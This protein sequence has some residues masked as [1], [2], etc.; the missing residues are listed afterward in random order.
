MALVRKLVIK[1]KLFE[2]TKIVPCQNPYPV[3]QVASELVGH[4]GHKLW[5]NEVQSSIFEHANQLSIA[6]A[7]DDSYAACYAKSMN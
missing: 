2:N 1:T 4:N 3:I 6:E 7:Y 5:R